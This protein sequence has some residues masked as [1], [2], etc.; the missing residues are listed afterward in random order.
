M[1]NHPYSTEES[2]REIRQRHVGASE[3]PALFGLSPF[4]TRWQL[5]HVKA[6]NLP[7]ADLDNNTAVLQGQHFEPAIAAYAGAKFGVNLRKVRRYITDDTTPGMGCSLD[8][9]QTGT[10]SLVP[11]EIKWA[12]QWGAWDWEGDDITTAPDNYLTQCHHQIACTGA[13]RANLFAFVGG[14]LKRLTV[15]RNDAIVAAIRTAV[16]QFWASIAAGQEPDP[17]YTA[18]ADGIAALSLLRPMAALDGDAEMVALA[19]RRFKA[20][21]LIKKLDEVSSA[22][23]ARMDVKMM[24]AAAERGAQPGQTV[25]CAAGPYRVTSTPV[26]ATEGKIV[27]EDMVGTHI[28]ARKAFRMLRVTQPTPK[29]KK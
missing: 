20:N 24:K 19:R 1:A 5:W 10:G 11:T 25:L 16:T 21:R 8:Y 2:W 29:E 18:D 7:A 12:V 9:E 13:D 15:E 4:M 3:S 14:D 23:R 28:G 22:A 27:T 26:A 6:G 17:D